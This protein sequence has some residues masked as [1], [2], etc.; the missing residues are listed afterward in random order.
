M[1]HL[2]EMCCAAC[3]EQLM[4]IRG[5]AYP[6]ETG[7]GDPIYAAAM[8]M[9]DRRA[10][11]TMV[12]ALLRNVATQRERTQAFERELAEL[13]G[14]VIELQRTRRPR[15]RAPL[16][17]YELRLCS[18]AEKIGRVLASSPAKARRKAP[19]KYRKGEVEAHPIHVESTAE[20]FARL[21]GSDGPAGSTTTVPPASSS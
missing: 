4:E 19:R 18:T 1:Q 14:N 6:D 10:L 17:W 21:T 20:R 5:R 9:E 16:I 2:E 13:A 3:R 11:L 12:Q 7:A 8:A 15:A